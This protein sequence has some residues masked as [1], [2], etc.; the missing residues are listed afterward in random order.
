MEQWRRWC[1][2]PDY[3]VG[4]EGP[5]VR[6]LFTAVETPL[7]SI[8]FT[9]DELLSGESIS[10]LHDF[11]SRAEKRMIR[12]RPEDVGERRIGHHG[13]FRPRFERSLWRPYLLPAL[14]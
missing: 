7:V 2:D 1:L 6:E 4:V 14:G 13:F 10:S 5:A 9:D 11:Y 3:L 8:S 12:I